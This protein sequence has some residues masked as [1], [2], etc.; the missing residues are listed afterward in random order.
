M[1]APKSV[2]NLWSYSYSGNQA[3]FDITESLLAKIENGVAVE[4]FVFKVT[5][6]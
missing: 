1:G 2:K 5:S 3:E 6:N 4:I